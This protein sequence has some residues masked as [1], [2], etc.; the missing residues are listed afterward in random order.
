MLAALLALAYL[1]LTP[2][3]GVPSA[4]F[5]REAEIKH[6]RVALLALPAL[7]AVAAATGADP[8]RYLSMQPV[9]AQ[10]AFFA[11]AGTLEGVTFAR[12]G[13]AFSLRED[14]VPGKLWDVPHPP[15]LAHAED[16]AGRAAMLAAA[17]VLALD[18]F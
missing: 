9:P 2:N 6:G 14:A 16:A 10:L 3:G 5:V 15:A 12:L 11:A 8:V 1:P 7:A 18:V 17:A 4:A 13:P